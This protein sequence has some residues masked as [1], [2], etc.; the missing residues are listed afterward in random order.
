MS[1][2]STPGIAAPVRRTPA[3]RFREFLHLE[4]SGGLV[5]MA[6]SVFAMMLANSPVAD[7]YNG[8]L[9]LPF[10]IRLGDAGLAKPLILWINDGLMA[11]FFLLVGLE[12]KRE[13]LEGHLSTLSSAALPAFAAVG[14][15]AVPALVFFALNQGDESAMRGWA[16]PAATDIA[17]ALG[18]LSLLG[19][20]VPPALK[21]FLLS[22]AIFDDLGAIAII[23]LFYTAELSTTALGIAALCLIGLAVLNRSGVTK[24]PGYFLIGIVLWV[25]VL[26]SGVH[27][28]LAGVALAAF[29]PMRSEAPEADCPLRALE[30]KLH[31]W[32]A[33]G[34]L[35]VFALANAGVPLTGLSPSDVLRPLPLGIA[36][37]LVLGKLVGVVGLSGIA[38]TVRAASLPEGVRWPHVIGAGLLCGVGFTMS[39]FISALAFEQGATSDPDLARL[40]VL[41]GSLIAGFAGYGVLRLVL[42]KSAA[43]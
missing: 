22:V 6:V 21:A 42:P 32:V 36:G 15:M 40:G 25:A 3:A 41:V 17:F 2:V 37:G 5:L 16:I 9:D 35:P 26:K 7:A 24:L 4:S 8:L 1:D 27:A 30:H 19:D 23:A 10:E 20:R 11:V 13:V 28:T 38:V 29:I 18:I 43:P 31:P 12:L 39:L 14:G 33:F 34:I